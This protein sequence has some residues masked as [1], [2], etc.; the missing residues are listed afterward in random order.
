MMQLFRHPDFTEELAS[1]IR[2]DGGQERVVRALRR[3]FLGE[4]SVSA[5]A[6]TILSDAATERLIAD[7]KSVFEQEGIPF[8]Y[9][10]D[11]TI[12]I[13]RHD[14]ELVKNKTLGV[15]THCFGRY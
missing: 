9:F 8:I 3:E 10:D 6:I 5:D 14:L 7:V 12:S 2:R 4:I 13:I 11:D 1:L 15:L